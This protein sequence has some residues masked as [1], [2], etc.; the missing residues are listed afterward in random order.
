MKLVLFLLCLVGSSMAGAFCKKKLMFSYFLEGRLKPTKKPNPLCP[1]IMNDCCTKDDINLVYDKYHGL[2]KPKLKAFKYRFEEAMKGIHELHAGVLRLKKHK[3]WEGDQKDF[4]E[5]RFE[6]WSEIDFKKMM[7]TLRRGFHISFDMFEKLHESFL[8]VMCDSDAHDNIMLETKQ[9]GVD[10]KVCLSTLNHNMAFLTAQNVELVDYFRKLQDHLDC[11]VFDKNYDLPFPFATEKYLRDDFEECFEK[12]APDSLSATCKTLCDELEMGAISPVYEGNYPFIDRATDYYSDMVRIIG[13]KQNSTAIDPLE[14]LEKLNNAKTKLKF[15]Q[16]EGKNQDKNEFMKGKEGLTVNDGN[17][18]MYR[19]ILTPYNTMTKEYEE[20]HK[21]NLDQTIHQERRHAKRRWI[22]MGGDMKIDSTKQPTGGKNG[23]KSKNTKKKSK[24]GGKKSGKLRRKLY[25]IDNNGDQVEMQHKKDTKDLRLIYPD[26]EQRVLRNGEGNGKGIINSEGILMK[27]G[28]KMPFVK[29]QLKKTPVKKTV[30][31]THKE[32]AKKSQTLKKLIGKAV[33]KQEV[34]D[35]KKTLLLKKKLAEKKRKAERKERLLK[36]EIEK[37]QSLP[38]S[39]KKLISEV[40]KVVEKELK[41]QSLK[42]RRILAEMFAEEDEMSE[43]H[44]GGGRLLEETSEAAI[45]KKN[46]VLYYTDWYESIHFI[47]NLKSNE[48]FKNLPP[49]FDIPFFEKTYVFNQGINLD[50]YVS[51]L[52]MEVTRKELEQL[53][54]GDANLD[55]DDVVM[56]TLLKT[57]GKKFKEGMQKTFTQEFSLLVNPR[58][59]SE[60]DEL[61]SR[62]EP[63]Y[64]DDEKFETTPS[65]YFDDDFVAALAHHIPHAHMAKPHHRKIIHPPKKPARKL[66]QE[67]YNLWKQTSFSSGLKEVF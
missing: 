9:M 63:L 14:T 22:S 45:I 67:E 57:C 2:V 30:V 21:S 62:L 19:N 40:S 32:S 56:E 64:G 52:R 4:C 46:P 27:N 24:K 51:T 17:D 23:D 48:I 29:N 12:L 8:C 33:K 49:Y 50:Q 15:F 53:L 18:F 41:N 16:I 38:E 47:E 10:S 3:Q 20:W 11:L 7:K 35:K 39:E 66:S 54:A 34:K 6:I 36:Q 65:I 13:A 43:F 58:K 60:D 31:K 59:L 61:L 55:P 25:F 28:K 44:L 37:K 42:R 1:A 5:D 26:G